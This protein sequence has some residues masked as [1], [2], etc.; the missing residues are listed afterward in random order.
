VLS[1]LLAL[2]LFMTVI[3]PDAT[4]ETRSVDG[5]SRLGGNSMDPN[6]IGAL[7]G[8][9]GIGSITLWRLTRQ[10]YRNSIGVVPLFTLGVALYILLITRSRTA[11]V[12]FTTASGSLIWFSAQKNRIVRARLIL[13][14]LVGVC[15]ILFNYQR[16]F[17]WTLRGDDVATLVSG[18]GRSDLW[19]GLLTEA[20]PKRPLLG[21]GYMMLGEFGP[22]M[23]NG[24][25]WTNAHNA[26][27]FALV[28]TGIVGFI[29]TVWMTLIGL[30]SALGKRF[31]HDPNRA[32][33]IA[34]QGLSASFL[35][36]LMDAMANY[37]MVGHPTAAMFVY[38]ILFVYAFP[39][40]QTP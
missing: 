21:H 34:H 17:E 9:L 27:I 8:L 18:T 11:L 22:Y 3:N 32:L 5:L 28:S 40:N 2:I 6:S 30:R 25:P 1:P 4:F 38:L 35:L 33:W 15:V 37:G 10:R 26:F 23:D 13:L 7:G 29:L 14:C 31:L 39:K 36:I 12:A 19:I 24:Y 16:I 20:F